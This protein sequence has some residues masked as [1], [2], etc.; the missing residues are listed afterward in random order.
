ML[1]TVPT[2]VEEGRYQ[3]AA[4]RISTELSSAV[5]DA[6]AGNG[7][8]GKARVSGAYFDLFEGSG[9]EARLAVVDPDLKGDLETRF[10]Q[11][12]ERVARGEAG[13]EVRAAAALLG[14]DVAAA[15]RKVE[16]SGGG[17]W[18]AF[19]S[20]LLVLLREG[21]EA[22]LII[23][24][25]VAFLTRA[26]RKRDVRMVGL[27][28]LAALGLSVVLAVALSFVAVGAG[29]ARE[30]LEGVTLL[31]A[32]AVLFYVS[33]WLI[34]KS[35]S[36]RWNAYI[37]QRLQDAAAESG[38]VAIFI[39]AFLAVFREGAETVLFI[40]AIAGDAPAG[41]GKLAVAAG[42]VVGSVGIGLLYVL[43]RR[44][45]VKLPM[46]LYFAVTGAMLYALSV[47]F[48]GKGVVELQ[49]A[50]RLPVTPLS[51][52]P[53]VPAIGLAPTLESVAVQCVLLFAVLASLAW[54]M[55]RRSGPQSVET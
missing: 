11:L 52:V 43:F 44:G 35:E 29:V 7:A 5:D 16:E 38:S 39:T 4:R 8:A 3:Q 10:G 51:W 25:M 14:E 34:S 47:I 49:A 36:A 2:T 21:F 33:H 54:V 31:L 53:S 41:S 46:G 12:R 18:G 17:A 6:A 40:A 32:S 19:I 37:K 20:A 15:A 27:A 42:V 9:L 45:L 55:G 48:A 22:L 23:G 24:G 26:N 1:V 28:V 13:P 50:G 30:V